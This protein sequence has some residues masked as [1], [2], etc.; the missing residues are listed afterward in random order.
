MR[1]TT[2][3]PPSS[4]CPVGRKGKDEGKKPALALL[5][6]AAAF[7]AP[8]SVAGFFLCRDSLLQGAFVA[9]ALALGAYL[10]L[11]ADMA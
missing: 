1:E 10:A 5:R 6:I 3:Q 9:F 8:A 11:S 2:L 7:S 4:G